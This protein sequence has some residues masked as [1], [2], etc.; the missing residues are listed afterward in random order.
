MTSFREK[1]GYPKQSGVDQTWRAGW[2]KSADMF[3]QLVED[4][5]SKHVFNDFC[6]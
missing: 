6:A 3:I 5:L 1:V 2:P 4:K